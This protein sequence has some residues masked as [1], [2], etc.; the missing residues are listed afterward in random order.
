[1]RTTPKSFLFN[2]YLLVG[3]VAIKDVDFINI[4]PSAPPVAEK[5][6]FTLAFGCGSTQRILRSQGYLGQ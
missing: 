6:L 4:D 1:M 5:D 2:V 3:L